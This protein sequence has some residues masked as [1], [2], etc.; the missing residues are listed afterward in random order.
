[1]ADF[2]TITVRVTPRASRDEVTG[3]SGDQLLVRL[4][5]A[6]VEGQANA[7]LRR[8][9]ARRLGVRLA[10]IEIVAGTTLPTKRL[11]I[12]GVSDAEVR[13]RLAV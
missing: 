2:I 10:D 6:P 1:M 13:E 8:L 5:A 11:R 9:L 7:A 12:S 3:W 4:R